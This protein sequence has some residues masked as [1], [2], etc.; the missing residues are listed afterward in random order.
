MPTQNKVTTN[1]TKMRILF[2]PNKLGKSENLVTV[3]ETGGK[4]SCLC[5]V[6]GV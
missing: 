6:N 5:I 3:G 1:E 2:L 4:E